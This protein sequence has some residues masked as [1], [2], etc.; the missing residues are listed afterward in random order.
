[1][2]TTPAGKLRSRLSEESREELRTAILNPVSWFKGVQTPD[3]YVTPWELTLYALSSMMTYAS[4][5]FT[6]RQDFL[7]KEWFHIKPNK[8]SVAGVISSIWDAINDPILGSFMDRKK[9][10]PK[11]WR[12]I[13]RISAITGNIFAVVKMLDGGLSETG[14]LVVLVTLNCMQ[15]IIGTMSS[16]STQK[17][18][19]GI[20]PYTQQRS[21][22]QVWSSVGSSMGYPLSAIPLLLMGLQDVL[23]LNDYQIIVVGS[24]IMLPLNI[25]ASML[26]SFIKQRVDFKYSGKPLNTLPSCPDTENYILSKEEEEALKEKEITLEEQ[27]KQQ[28][29]EMK[30]ANAAYK[31]AKA[32]RKALLSQMSRRERREWKRAHPDDFREKVA[33]GEIPLD[34]ETGEPKLSMLQSFEV[35]KYNKY[36]ILNTIGNFITVFTPSVDQTLVYRY[37]VPKLKVGNKEITGEIFLLLRDQ[38]IGTPV[39]FTKPFSRQLVN[40]CG[41]P[42]RVVQINSVFNIVASLI[43]FALGINKFWKL[44]VIMLLD[45]VSYVIGDMS[46]L[47]GT[48]LNYEMLDYVE[49]KTGMRTEGV[50]NAIDGLFAKIVTNNI[51]TVTGNAFLQWTGYTGGYKESGEALPERFQKYMWPMFTLATAFDN[52]VFLVLRSFLKHTPED[53]KR[54]EEELIAL[55]KAASDQTDQVDQ[56]DKASTKE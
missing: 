40:L 36:F 32:E 42:L 56:T 21:R 17:M 53:A 44:A 38:I 20:S 12:W 5:G 7:F 54:V 51:G 16:V 25:M 9:M 43:K 39:T 27:S 6:G 37:L 19:A 13:I 46:A 26:L 18:N 2:A 10:G 31:R 50:T 4:S 34:P 1:M 33:R 22:A 30:R 14:H 35:V 29:E 8:L 45:S 11:Q 3:G 41:G 15:D 24:I 28:E 23:N 55:R 52:A 49:L 47:A 48:M